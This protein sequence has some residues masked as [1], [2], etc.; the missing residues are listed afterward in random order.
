MTGTNVRHKATFKTITTP[1]ELHFRM[2]RKERKHKILYLFGFLAVN[3]GTYISVTW[4][5]GPVLVFEM[6][7]LKTESA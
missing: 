6:S 4:C 2:K 7:R 1:L 3:E 5:A